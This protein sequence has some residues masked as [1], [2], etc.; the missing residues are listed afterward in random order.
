VDL[1]QANPLGAVKMA[2]RN[3]LI[4]GVIACWTLLWISHVGLQ[5]N[6]INY[7]DRKFE[8]GVA[9]S[10]AS[11]AL[12]GLLVAVF[13]KLIIPRLGLERS[14]T[15][16]LLVYALSQLLIAAAPGVSTARGHLGTPVVLLGLI[17]A[18]AGTVAFPSTLAFLSNQV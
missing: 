14:I 17:L 16:G 10:G 4:T 11:L 15:Y 13:P 1:K 9:Q 12:M 3:N 7:T 5:I 2:S 6:W 8:W 18:S